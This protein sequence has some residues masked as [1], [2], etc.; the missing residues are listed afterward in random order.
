M[1]IEEIV[2]ILGVEKLDESQQTLV[3]EKLDSIIDVKARERADSILGE[4]KERLVT[5]YETKFEDYKK[6]ITSKFS[7]FVDSVLD[8]ELTIP[9][10]VMEYARKGELYTDLVEQFKIRMGID[11]GVLDEEAKALL[12]EA[13]N[14]ITKLKAKANE[15][16]S[17][18]AELENDTKQMA[19]NLYLRKK[20]D[21]LSEASRIRVLS[22]L[23]DITDKKEIDRKYDIVMETVLKEE[24][25]VGTELPEPEAETEEFISSSCGAIMKDRIITTCP[26]CS[27]SLVPVV[28]SIVPAEEEGQGSMEVPTEEK[29]VATIQE[30]DSPFNRVKAQWVKILKENKF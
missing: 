10:K 24:V 20:C 5:E 12:K 11:E 25:A 22:I 13:K 29:P 27:G 16:I 3:K 23:G 15:V 26:E 8:Q 28:D 18:N 6:D 9:E 7:N 19:A 17:R 21:G 2:K 14:E 1:L 4:E 30:D